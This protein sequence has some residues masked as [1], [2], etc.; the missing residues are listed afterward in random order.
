VRLR[1]LH[2]V[3][4][5]RDED[6]HLP[7]ALDALGV[8]VD[9]VRSWAPDLAVGV[10]VVLDTCR[11]S[12]EQV[13]AARPWVDALVVSHGVVGRTRAA[14][15]DRARQLVRDL[16]GDQVWVACTDADSEVP[17][18]W[19]VRQVGLADEGAEYYLGVVHPDSGQLDPLT[20]AG[21]WARHQLVEGHTHVHGANMGFTLA[22]Y[23][24]VGGFEPVGSGEDVRLAAALC[25]TG[26]RG[27]ATARNPVLTS[28][29]TAGR[30]PRGFASY[31]L[32]LESPD[33][34]P[35]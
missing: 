19:L 26:R 22:A 11:D 2:V 4:P 23:D 27:V 21:W 8:A 35:A 33:G 12:S 7:A 13:V 28:G 17:P 29:R 20:R 10:T 1:A 24:A 14:G 6:A 15:V 32:D 30:A 9:T 5:A 31:L 34:A 18:Q 3:V 25:A 16:P